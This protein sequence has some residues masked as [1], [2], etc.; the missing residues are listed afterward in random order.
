MS[1]CS[2]VKCTNSRIRCEFKRKRGN[3]KAGELSG[4]EAQ[5]ASHCSLTCAAM[6]IWSSEER[7][8]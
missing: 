5:E 6:A 3:M 4:T 2:D 1:L 7:F 8:S